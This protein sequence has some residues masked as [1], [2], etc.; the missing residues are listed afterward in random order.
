M[1]ID[2]KKLDRALNPRNVA[3]VGD[4]KAGNYTWL[5]SMSTVQGRLYSVQIDENE[6]PGIEELRVP[7]YKSLVDIPD[8]I[9]Y[10]LVAVPRTV[11]PVVL[12]D[13]IAK[14]VGG[15]A[16]FSSGFA[17][18]DTK[19]GVELQTLV[20]QIAREAGL[21]M[22]GPNCMGLYNPATGVRFN[23]NQAVGFEGSVAFAS[24]SGGHGGSFSHA[25]YAAG[26]PVN[27]VV[28]FGNGVVLENADYL[29]YFAQDPNTKCIAMYVEGLQDGRRFFRLLRETT[30]HKP[31]VLW[32]GG[33]TE[34]GQRMTASHTGS[35]AGDVVMWDTLCRQSGAIQVDS[36]EEMIDV[37]RAIT[38]LSPFTG[39]GMGIIGGTGGQSV[40]MSDAFS[41]PGLRVPLLTDASYERL[42]TFF[43]LIGAS[44]RNPIDVGGF[45][46]EEIETILD[47]LI[48]DPNVDC[49]VS[50]L[51]IRGGAQSDQIGN[52]VQVRDRSSKPVIAVLIS[53]APL[54]EGEQLQEVEQELREARIPTFFSY[55]SAARAIKRVVDYHRFHHSPE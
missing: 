40:S 13:C 48:N 23:Q 41:R 33:V 46:R 3:V 2:V 20:T 22:L 30:P 6:L 16:V 37:L 54:R 45:N 12:R 34:A 52:L 53:D 15:V 11:V 27:K 47:T 18:T 9:D 21:V 38:L 32:K 17:E 24:Q 43:R 49:M 8:D 10:V 25:A 5:N 55:D 50:R 1:A 42:G 19:E 28:S 7:N 39:D 35:L 36:L 51:G 31:V 29:E 44:Y 4:R 14:G 26:I